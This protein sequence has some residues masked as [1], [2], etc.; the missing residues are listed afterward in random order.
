MRNK[1]NDLLGVGHDKAKVETAFENRVDCISHH[2]SGACF[3]WNAQ[4]DVARVQGLRSLR[5]LE[6]VDCMLETIPEAFSALS[7]LTLLD[8]R[9]N[10]FSSVTLDYREAW[11]WWPLTLSR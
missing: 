9:G 8:V 10:G 7:A 11:A 3:N 6:V 5:R 4:N 1:Q 2:A